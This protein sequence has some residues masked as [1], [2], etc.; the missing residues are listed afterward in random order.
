M[1]FSVDSKLEDLLAEFR[2]FGES[3]TAVS[4]VGEN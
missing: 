3:G 4:R 2:V 1:A